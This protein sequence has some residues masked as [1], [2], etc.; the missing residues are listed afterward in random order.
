VEAEVDITSISTAG[1]DASAGGG[2]DTRPPLTR[3]VYL[4]HPCASRWGAASTVA[5][6]VGDGRGSSIRLRLNTPSPAYLALAP[7]R[8]MMLVGRLI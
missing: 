1:D 2:A 3:K 6:N 5:S 7:T 8:E 4:C